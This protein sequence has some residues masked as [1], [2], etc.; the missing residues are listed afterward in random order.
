VLNLREAYGSLRPQACTVTLKNDTIGPS[1]LFEALVIGQRLNISFVADCLDPAFWEQ[2]QV[3]VRQRL[4]AAIST[5]EPSLS[6]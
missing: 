5:S 4:D 3:A 6:G 1:T 2:L